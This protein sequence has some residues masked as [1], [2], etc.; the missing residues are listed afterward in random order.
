MPS[1]PTRL[2]L[3]AA[4]VLAAGTATA[5]PPFTLVRTIPDCCDGGGGSTFA[6]S[7]AAATIPGATGGAPDGVLVG[8]P[9]QGLGRAVLF[10]ADGG[11]V[12]QLEP[13]APSRGFG[14][15]VAAAPAVLGVGAPDVD[16]VYLFDARTH[17][18]AHTLVDPRGNGAGHAYG[19]ALAVGA[20][21]VVVGAP[22]DDVDGT[23]AG[24]A[25]VFDRRTGAL[26]FALA[27]PAAF[28][29][30]RFG[31][32]VAIV[33]DD[34]VVGASAEGARGA[35]GRVSAYARES[36]TLRW[37]RTAPPSADARLF[38]YALAADARR[39]VVGAP[40]RDGED[41]A[42]LAVVLERATGVPLYALAAP[43]P[44]SCDFFGGAVAIGGGSVVV[45]ARLAGEPDAGAVH[46]FAAATGR[47][48]ASFA[49]A[50]DETRLGWS[51]AAL[52]GSVVAGAAGR[53][54]T[55]RIYRRA[56]D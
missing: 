33:G 40:C 41:P 32:A 17:G 14:R 19:A 53:A 34:V 27:P 56:R 43:S 49:S 23:D 28:P 7:I 54:G 2:V 11:I 22:F 47:R 44:E 4:L 5:G 25:Y 3:V 12:A 45:G 29:G 35:R 9:S 10:D 38:G 42:G 48:L 50:G 1:R 46:V 55:V 37:T 24:A 20:H 15:V 6:A 52:G 21:D 30:A 51:V 31:T 36:G 8:I 26:R 13:A 39:I 16:T 18:L